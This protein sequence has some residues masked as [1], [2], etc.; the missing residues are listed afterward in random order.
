MHY[1]E[2]YDSDFNKAVGV[3]ERIRKYMEIFQTV[4]YRPEDKRG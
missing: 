3:T 1:Y 4:Q 2:T